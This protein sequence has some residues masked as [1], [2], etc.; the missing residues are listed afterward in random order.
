MHKN[1]NGT[2]IYGVSDGGAGGA[3]HKGPHP[4][5]DVLDSS[6]R[7]LPYM[8]AT[9]QEISLN[10]ASKRRTADVERGLGLTGNLFG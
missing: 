6:A 7:H 9:R 4:R 1:L 5:D 10:L 8:F 2:Q 3:L